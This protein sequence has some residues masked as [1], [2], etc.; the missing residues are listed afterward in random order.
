MEEKETPTSVEDIDNDGF[1]TEMG[2]CDD[3][4]NLVNPSV[5]E[6]CDGIDN[7]QVMM[8]SMRKQ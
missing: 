5:A 4:N 2:D 7:N 8:K 1:T 3:F 6:V